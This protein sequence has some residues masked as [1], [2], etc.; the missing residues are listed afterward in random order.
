MGTSH[1]KSSRNLIPFVHPVAKRERERD[2]ERERER[3]EEM[4]HFCGALRL[5]KE[6]Q[7][8]QR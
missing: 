5:R 3:R 1:D 4:C 6:N 8:H 7:H 2:K